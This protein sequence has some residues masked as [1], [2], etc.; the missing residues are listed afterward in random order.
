MGARAP[1]CKDYYLQG[2]VS[3]RT[4]GCDR[5]RAERDPTSR[6]VL[7]ST[8][9]D[10]FSSVGDILAGSRNGIAAAEEER[11]TR[12][13]EQDESQYLRIFVHGK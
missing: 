7:F 9:L 2:R 12:K 3:S 5:Y 4:T 11:R 10:G 6:R 8:L 13:R 1:H